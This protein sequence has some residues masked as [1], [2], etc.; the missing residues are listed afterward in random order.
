MSRNITDQK[1]FVAE[2]IK[3]HVETIKQQQS[4]L[5]NQ[6]KDFRIEKELGRGSFGVVY[7]VRPL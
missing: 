3:R 2:L 1:E 6:V 4:D 7:L 5:G